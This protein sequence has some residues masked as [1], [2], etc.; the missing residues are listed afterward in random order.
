MAARESKDL[1]VFFF[2]F[3]NFGTIFSSRAQIDC[4][5]AIDLSSSHLWYSFCFL[6][7]V[8]RLEEKLCSRNPARTKEVISLHRKDPERL[9]N[10]QK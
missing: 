4:S 1:G 5:L 3:D 2:A 9:Q 6:C 7:A 10:E 8:W